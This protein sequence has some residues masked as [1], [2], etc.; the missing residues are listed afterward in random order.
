[1]LSIEEKQAFYLFN[2]VS[3]SEGVQQLCLPFIFKMKI[4]KEDS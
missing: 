3:K 4:E 1:M 2:E